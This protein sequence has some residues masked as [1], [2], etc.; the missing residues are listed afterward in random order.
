MRAIHEARTIEHLL[1]EVSAWSAEEN[2]DWD[3]HPNS[4]DIVVLLTANP[5]KNLQN[6]KLT[7][8][9]ELFPNYLSH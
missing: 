1:D 6:G 9:F 8:D 4:Y 7:I 2:E 3:G 5:L